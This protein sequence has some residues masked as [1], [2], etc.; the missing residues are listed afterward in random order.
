MDTSPAAATRLQ[1]ILGRLLPL[2]ERLAYALRALSLLGLGLVAW[3]FVWM[4]FLRGFGLWT[5]LIF[6]VVALLPV[7]LLMRFWWSLAELRE[8]PQRLSSMRAGV[9]AEVA[10]TVQSLRAGDRTRALGLIAQAKRLFEVR[11]LL[12]QLDD[13]VGQYLSVGLLV[14]PLML[15][16]G[17]LS[18]LFVGLL[19][20]VGVGLALGQLF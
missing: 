14:N 10:S 12:G 11:S 6:G 4:Y 17:V 19:L 9:S 7:L 16:L 3:L 1:A 13:V 15:L 8:L 20:V 18:L 2:A 5:A